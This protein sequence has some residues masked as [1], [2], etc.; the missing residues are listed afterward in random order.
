MNESFLERPIYSA[1]LEM[2]EE[3]AF[4][5]QVCEQEPP[6]TAD[7]RAKFAKLWGLIVNSEVFKAA[8]NYL[9]KQS[10]L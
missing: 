7:R 9:D 1:L 2:Y 6:M 8:Y 10:I 3:N 5:Q 4:H